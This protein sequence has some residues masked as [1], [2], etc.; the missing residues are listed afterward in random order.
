[1]NSA[2]EESSSIN[3]QGSNSSEKE[4]MFDL[5]MDPVAS[6]S[7]TKQV[8]REEPQRVSSME[9]KAVFEKEFGSEPFRDAFHAW[10]QSDS[11]F[12]DLPRPTV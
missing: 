1:L 8:S 5:E 2:K 3:E 6:S 10:I 7:K 4:L 11:S 9:E 12:F